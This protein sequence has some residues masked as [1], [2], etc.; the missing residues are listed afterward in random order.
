MESRLHRGPRP[1]REGYNI[2]EGALIRSTSRLRR[3]EGVLAAVDCDY[4]TNAITYTRSHPRHLRIR[5]T[6]RSA[7]V[8][9]RCRGSRCRLQENQVLHQ[10]DVV[11]SCICPTA[12]TSSYWLTIPTAVIIAAVRERLQAGR[13]R[14]LRSRCAT[15]RAAVSAM[16]TTSVFGS[17]GATSVAQDRCAGAAPPK[18][19]PSRTFSSTTTIGAS[20]SP[21]RS[22]CPAAAERSRSDRRFLRVRLSVLR[23]RRQH[24]PVAKNVASLI[25]AC[26]WRR[27]E[28]PMD[29]PRGCDRLFARTRHC[30]AGEASPTG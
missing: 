8:M 24:R 13:R 2:V 30:P 28:P 27:G 29:S 14:R 15:S 5:W 22:R 4:Y 18:S 3:Q 21:A 25:A 9:A 19:P 20:V 7:V 1:S 10:R 11:G 12:C 26:R 23:G 17:G 6:G 16:A